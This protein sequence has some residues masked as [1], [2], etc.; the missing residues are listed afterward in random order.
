MF[1]SIVSMVNSQVSDSLLDKGIDAIESWDFRLADSLIYE[2][3]KID[4]SENKRDP[5]KYYNLGVVKRELENYD[6]AVALFDSVIL[7]SPNFYEAYLNRGVCNFLNNKL[8]LAIIDANKAIFINSNEVEGYLWRAYFYEHK[9]EWAK[10]NLDYTSALMIHKDVRLLTYRAINNARMGKKN[11]SWAD[12]NTAETD[13]GSNN[14]YL[15]KA[16]IYFTFFLIMRICADS[17]LILK[18]DSNSKKSR[19]NLLKLI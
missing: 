17:M 15:N 19:M 16:K 4:I 3:I 12:L 7:I 13:F 14:Y 9:K 2:S 5:L 6:L 8:E 10:A 18:T 1:I 11:E